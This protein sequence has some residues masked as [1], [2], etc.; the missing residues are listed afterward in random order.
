MKFAASAGSIVDRSALPGPMVR[1]VMRDG[2]LRRQVMAALQALRAAVFPARCLHCRRL[3]PAAVSGSEEPAPASGDG[4]LLRPYF[5]RDCRSAVTPVSSPLCPR[6][7]IMFQSRV[8]ADH[9]CGRCLERAPPFHMARAALVYDRSTVDIIHC[10]KYRGKTRLAAPLGT[11]LW[12]TFARDWVGR[13]VDL[14]LPVPLHRRRLR[15]RGFNQ[16]DLLLREWQTQMHPAA[17]PPMGTGVL[18]R[19]RTAAPQAG[20]GRRERESN[21]RGVFTVR[22][23]ELV[24]GRNILL[25]DD[26]ITTGATAGEC[27]RVLLASGAARVDVLALARVI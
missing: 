2:R 8:G 1:A 13:T 5:C 6:C 9:L 23:P 18:E 25:V 4:D 24:D 17:M 15:R 12:H 26:V 10:Y 7:G 14:V 27:A 20:L 22:R 3:L 21:I 19:T 11:F 16:S